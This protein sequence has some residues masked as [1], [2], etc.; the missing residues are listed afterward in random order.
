MLKTNSVSLVTKAGHA[1]QRFANR[2]DARKRKRFWEIV[3]D[4]QSLLG[5][6]LSKSG[7]K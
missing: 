5:E 7:T 2:L 4:W 6:D 3:K 1:D